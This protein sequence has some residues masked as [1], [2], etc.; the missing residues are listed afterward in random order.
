MDMAAVSI[1][2]VISFVI[3][4]IV[5][6][7][8]IYVV[9]KIFGEKEG[10]K[11]ALATA[12]IGAIIYSVVYYLFGNGLLAGIVGGLAWL[13]SLR[14]IYNIGWLKAILIGVIIWIITS[15]VGVLLPTAPGP[16]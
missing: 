10:I 8:I 2:A 11:A 13:L 14:W 12:V 5:S 15:I 9:T 16:L 7:I 4:L 6:T 1:W 3:G